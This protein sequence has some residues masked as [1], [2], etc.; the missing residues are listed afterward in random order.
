MKRCTPSTTLKMKTCSSQEVVRR[1]SGMRRPLFPSPC[2]LLPERHFSSSP[3]LREAVDPCPLLVIHCVSRLL[4]H[5]LTITLRVSF[6]P[7]LERPTCF[8]RPFKSSFALLTKCIIYMNQW[9]ISELRTSAMFLLMI[10]SQ[11]KSVPVSMRVTCYCSCSRC[12]R[13]SRSLFISHI[14]AAQ[15]R[16]ANKNILI[17]L[18]I[19]QLT[20]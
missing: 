8:T 10:Q 15:G 17:Y 4:C 1:T 12:S 5:P 9:K 11:T 3:P 2:V 6:Q 13:S 19:E 18:N 14:H 7:R 20:K 16:Q